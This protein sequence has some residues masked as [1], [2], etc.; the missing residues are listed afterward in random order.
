M[1]Q[2]MTFL[3]AL[4]ALGCSSNSNEGFPDP[5]KY[6]IV[7]SITQVPDSVCVETASEIRFSV[8]KKDYSGDFQI[9]IDSIVPEFG[10][11]DY[12]MFP[13]DGSVPPEAWK[14]KKGVTLQINSLPLNEVK[15]I[16]AGK[17]NILRFSNP[18]VIGE[19]KVFINITDDDKQTK[20]EEIKLKVWS[21]E[22]IIKFYQKNIGFDEDK[23]F[24][25]LNKK[26]T[27]SPLSEDLKGKRVDTI[28]T[29]E[30]PM[31]GH[32]GEWTVPGQSIICYI[33]QEG[34]NDFYYNVSG[35][36]STTSWATRWD[37]D[38]NAH[39]KQQKSGFHGIMFETGTK[40]DVGILY[41]TIHLIDKW[42][43]EK[44]TTITYKAFGRNDMI[45][46]HCTPSENMWWAHYIAD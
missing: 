6:P 3:F 45:P 8:S 46:S 32:P 7:I 25:E 23:Y 22:I 12:S 40:T 15:K 29:Q 18:L 27:Y 4:L 2:T 5:E 38:V 17:D 34:N 21:P 41:F 30:K 44:M 10:Y 19:Y 14:I 1:K 20:K 16:E 35:E 39:Q 31:A 33:G 37:G 43:K 42:G 9:S 11:W 36:N 13:E 26:F 24:E 28:Y